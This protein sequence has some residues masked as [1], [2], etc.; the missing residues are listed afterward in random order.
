[1][2]DKEKAIIEKIID[3]GIWDIGDGHGK[4]KTWAIRGLEKIGNPLHFD[5]IVEIVV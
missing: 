3:Y 5:A 4:I 1:M 2:T